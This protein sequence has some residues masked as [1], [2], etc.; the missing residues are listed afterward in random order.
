MNIQ[1]MRPESPFCEELRASIAGGTQAKFKP[2]E[3]ENPALSLEE[4]M[5]PELEEKEKT[6]VILTG[7]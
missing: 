3:K 5:N 2:S 4:K 1:E 6:K 7:N